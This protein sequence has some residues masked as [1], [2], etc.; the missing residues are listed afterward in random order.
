MTV[1]IAA[2]CGNGAIF[3][4]ADQMISG[5]DVQYEPKVSKIISITNAIVAMI[6]GDSFLHT[7]ILRNVGLTVAERVRTE[8]TRWWGAQEIAELYR[9]SRNAAR[10]QR[11][12]S[13]ILA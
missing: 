7:E 1:C 12:E 5:G 8:P 10:Q 11:A 6:A 13:A 4:A 9:N 3:C 2:R